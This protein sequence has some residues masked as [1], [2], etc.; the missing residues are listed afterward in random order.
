MELRLD[1][2]SA[3]VTGASRGIGLAIAQRFAEAGAAVTLSARKPEELEQAAASLLAAVPGAQVAWRV[4][5]A[6]DPAAAEACVADA[7]ERWGRLDILVNN[8]AT[9]P[10][11]GPLV[12][13]DGPRAQK[14]VEVNQFGPLAWVQ[15]A[16]R[17]AMA[18]HG[19]VVLNV[20]SIGGLSPEPGMGWYGVTKA[21][22]VHLTRQLA[23]ELAPG[24]R[25]N[26]LAPGLVRTVFARALWEDH[27]DRVASRLPLKRLGEPD[28]VAKAALF[29]CSDAA[30]WITGSTLVVDGGAMVTPSGGV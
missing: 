18:E 15:A 28:D 20:A 1:G 9:N 8:A 21:A 3:L 27:G 16:W 4:A 25:V 19:G 11:Y 14:T 17:A 2:R 24:V 30:S 10:Y 7:L 12:G 29:L 22:L 23:A 13:L 6:G 26:A 5:H